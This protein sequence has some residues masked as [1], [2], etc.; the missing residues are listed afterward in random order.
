MRDRNDLEPAFDALADLHEIL[1]ALFANEHC[2]N[3]PAQGREQ[4][5]L[6]GDHAKLIAVGVIESRP[7][8]GGTIGARQEELFTFDYEEIAA[9]YAETARKLS[10]LT[11]DLALLGCNDRYFLL[12][13]LLGRQ[14]AAP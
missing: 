5:L 2:F 14:D 6:H 1:G 4:L 9:W 13:V 7:G 3:A 10:P 11:G 12:T 8:A